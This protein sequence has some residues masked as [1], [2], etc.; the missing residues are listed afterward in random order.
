MSKD[1]R[2]PEPPPD[3][4]EGFLSGG[5]LFGCFVVAGFLTSTLSFPL[6]SLLELQQT[7]PCWHVLCLINVDGLVQ[8]DSM[9]CGI[10]TPGHLS[11]VFGNGLGVV[12]LAG[13]DFST[14]LVRQ[15]L[16][17]PGQ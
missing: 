4:L 17:F 13:L 6:S 3:G 7:V 9:M 10:Q 12:F 5:F 11:F 14:F 16:P 8:N 2:S 15:H 1:V